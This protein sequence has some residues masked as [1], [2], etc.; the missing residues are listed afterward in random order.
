MGIITLLDTASIALQDK[1]KSVLYRLSKQITASATL[2]LN[3]GKRL[4]T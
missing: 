2:S 4:K 1:R 3:K